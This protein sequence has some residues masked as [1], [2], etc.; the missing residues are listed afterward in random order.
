[1]ISL[2]RLYW[3]KIIKEI[4]SILFIILIS[5]GRHESDSI[6]TVQLLNSPERSIKNLSEIGIDID[7]IPLQ[8]V[9]NSMISNINILKVSDNCIYIGTLDKIFC[10]DNSGRYLFNLDKK[11]RGPEEYEYII[12]FDIDPTSKALV[13]QTRKKIL[14]Y[15]QEH[16]GFHFIEKLSL[17]T[18]PAKINFLNDTDRLL[19]QFSNEDGTKP[20]SNVLINFDGEPLK[21]WPNYL[22]YRLIDGNVSYLGY[23]RL[24]YY[25]NNFLFYKE[26]QN[27]TLFRV[28]KSYESEPILILDSGEKRLTPTARATGKEFSKHMSDYFLIKEILGSDK[29]FYFSYYYNQIESHEIYDKTINRTFSVSEKDFLKDDLGG[30]IN[31]KPM[32]CNNGYLYSWVDAFKLNEFY[33]DLSSKSINIKYPEKNKSF[34]NIVQGIKEDDN[35]IIIRVK[36]K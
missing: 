14:F 3:M 6:V 35:P 10:F 27:D 32:Y 28:N 21:I 17:I 30:G 31:F 1:V 20:N 11:G 26:L 33:S 2:Q 15:R 29:L 22:H 23:E 4:S 19:L 12:D 7:Y 25:Y 18:S 9:E 5:C 13:L 34:L 24:S 16:D 8:T 36:I